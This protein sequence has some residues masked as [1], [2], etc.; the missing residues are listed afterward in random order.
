MLL[1]AT[2]NTKL[3]IGL[4]TAAIAQETKYANYQQ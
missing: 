3:Q 1:S 2:T 4:V